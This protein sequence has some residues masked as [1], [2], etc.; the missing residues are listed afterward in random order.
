MK[1]QIIFQLEIPLVE[2]RKVIAGQSCYFQRKAK[3]RYIP[4][5]GSEVF[6][7][8][9]IGNRTVSTY[10]ITEVRFEH[11]LE[12][13]DMRQMI[14]IFIVLKDLT[15]TSDEIVLKIFQAMKNNPD[16]MVM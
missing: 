12:S 13:D 11:Y 3:L 5:T 6:V 10:V 16:W 1:S 14:Y 15:I 4:P 9:G 2:D 8:N 7:E